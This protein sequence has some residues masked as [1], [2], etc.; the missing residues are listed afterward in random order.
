MQETRAVQPWSQ[1]MPAAL[2][3]VQAAVSSWFRVTTDAV[4]RKKSVMKLLVGWGLLL[5]RGTVGALW[6]LLLES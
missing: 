6:E 3:D 4:S 5:L 1:L 2:L